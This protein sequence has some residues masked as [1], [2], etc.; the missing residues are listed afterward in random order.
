MFQKAQ[1]NQTK[2]RLCLAGPAGS[3]KTYSALQIAK[4]LGGR[5]AMIDSERGSGALYANICDYDV[6]QLNPPFDPKFYIEG[7]KAA[8]DAGYDVLIIDSLSHAWSG[9][10]GILTIHDRVAKA[11]R[12]SFDA[13]REVTPQHNLLV[14]AILSST[15][16][17]IVTMRTKTGYEVITENGKTKV[18]KVGLA[19]IQ[20]EG[21]EYEFTCVLDLS[22]EGHIATASKDRTGLFD[23]I[24]FSPIPNTGR[25]LLHWLENSQ[26]EPDHHRLLELLA[27]LGL[28]KQESEYTLYA[29]K[30]YGV[31]DLGSLS[32]GQIKEQLALLQQCKEKQEKLRQFEDILR[33]QKLA[34]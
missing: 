11:V 23:G 8:E 6:L 18:S 19:P 28:T 1:R 7:I 17:V 32:L 29:A 26:E 25:A 20:R 24:R 30:R 10:G 2:L 4:G 5:I 12:N 22:A 16:H 15:C 3:G 33:Q 34:A 27:D 9:E 13:W 21:L 14:D 31:P